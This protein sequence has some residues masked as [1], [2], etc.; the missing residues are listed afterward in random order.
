M[1]DVNTIDVNRAIYCLTSVHAGGNPRT[2]E[3]G[4]PNLRCS[5]EMRGIPER[6]FSY[7]Q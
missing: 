7:Y 3:S 6:D 4:I 5:H 2:S 1:I